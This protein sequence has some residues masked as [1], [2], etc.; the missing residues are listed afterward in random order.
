[1]SVSRLKTG[2]CNGMANALVILGFL[3]TLASCQKEEGFGGT[4][5]IKGTLIEKH[6]ND[7]FSRLIYENPAVDEE[8]F[9][10]FGDDPVL[11]DRVFTSLTGEFRF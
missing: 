2:A 11:G 9:I 3:L 4:G 6:Y 10:V 1:M 5:A 7:D 8:V